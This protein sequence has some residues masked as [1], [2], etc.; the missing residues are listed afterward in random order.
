MTQFSSIWLIDR[1]LS[2]ATT[3]DKTGHGRN[4]SEGVLRISLCSIFT[5]ATPSDC[6]VSYI[7]HSLDLCRDA[8]IVFCSS[9]LLSQKQ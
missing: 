6:L 7:G 8:D 5:E 1:T 2:G 9:Y 3:P 4:G